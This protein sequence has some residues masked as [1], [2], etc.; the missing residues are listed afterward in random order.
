MIQS[1][2]PANDQPLQSFALLSADELD[3]RLT[4]ATKGFAVWR[5]SRLDERTGLLSRLGDLFEADKLRLGRL[6]TD[7]MGKTLASAVA[8]VEKC[9]SAFRYYAENGPAFL[10]DEPFSLDKGRGLARRLPLGVILAVMPWNFP[11][12]QV[13]RFLAPTL[14]AGNAGLLKHASNVGG[15]AQA[16]EETVRRAGAPEGVFQNLFLESGRISDVIADP[17]VA[18]VTLTGSEGAGMS[19]GAAAGRA[20]KKCVLELGGSDPF[21]VMPSA[22]V[23]LAAETAVKARVLNAGQSCICAKRMIVHQAVYDRFLDRMAGAM[24]RLKVGDPTDPATDVGPLSSKKARDD[25]QAQVEAAVKAGAHRLTGAEPIPGPG[26]FY[27]PGILTGIPPGAAAR[28]E[29]FFGPVAMVFK[30]QDVNDALAIANEA[31]FGLGS[32]IWTHDATEQQRLIDDLQTGLTA[33]NG[34]LASDPRA[35]FGGVKRSG[36]GRELGPWGLHEFMNLKAVMLPG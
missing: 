36:H 17:R 26:A 6:M 10:Q 29:E 22:D 9:A 11:F 23:D 16:I 13:V 14:M 18:A 4:L 34:M 8:E 7:E 32:S 21:I 30:A 28:Y 1:I 24:E 25:L 35:P 20:L 15:C 12:W 33:V 27:R 2:N 5:S 31:P 19:V 3:A